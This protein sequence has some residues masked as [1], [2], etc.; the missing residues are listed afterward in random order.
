MRRCTL[1]TPDELDR[2]FGRIDDKRSP[3]Y[4]GFG[5]VL[6]TGAEPAIVQRTNYFDD[7]VFDQH[8]D[9]HPDHPNRP[10]HERIVGLTDEDLDRLQQLA[11]PE[12][13]FDWHVID[14]D[15][16]RAGDPLCSVHGFGPSP[17]DIDAAM[18]VAYSFESTHTIVKRRIRKRNNGKD[19]TEA[20]EDEDHVSPHFPDN[21]TSIQLLAP[22]DGFVE[23]TDVVRHQVYWPSEIQDQPG[24]RDGSTLP[25]LHH[26]E[27]PPGRG[28]YTS[29]L[30]PGHCAVRMR[31]KSLPADAHLGTNRGLPELVAA[32]ERWSA[33]CLDHFERRLAHIRKVKTGWMALAVSALLIPVAYLLFGGGIQPVLGSFGTVLASLVAL[34]IVGFAVFKIQIINSDVPM[35]EATRSELAKPTRH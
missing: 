2:Y 19:D 16:V 8:Y 27:A 13:Y 20:F 7:P 23:L 24:E 10:W 9:P 22:C 1:I 25:T 17:E 26:T 28:V 5:L 15:R 34:G 12:I 30:E 35:F 18:R 4:P 32:K 21:G 6:I 33:F 11:S 14:G 31:A 29:A 3:V